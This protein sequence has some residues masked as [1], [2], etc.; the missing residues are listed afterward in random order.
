MGPMIAIIS[1]NPAPQARADP[2][3]PSNRCE[4]A[5]RLARPISCR[6]NIYRFQRMPVAM[7]IAQATDTLQMLR[8]VGSGLP[9]QQR[10]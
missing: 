10:R 9:R 1:A 5:S 2:P 4:H 7:F 6:G 8:D 3:S